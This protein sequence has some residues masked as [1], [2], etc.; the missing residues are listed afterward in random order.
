MYTLKLGYVFLTIREK[1]EGSVTVNWVTFFCHQ[2]KRRRERN[3][4]LGY[5]FLAIR[6]KEEGSV[7]VNWVTLF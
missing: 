5:V 2:R 7:T 6:E 3:G 1:E 4:K